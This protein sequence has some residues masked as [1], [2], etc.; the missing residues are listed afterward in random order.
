MKTIIK[1]ISVFFISLLLSYV[2]FSTIPVIADSGW[3][4]DYG[5]W[6]GSDWGGSD[7][8]GSDWGSSDWGSSDWGSSDWSSSDYGSSD[9]AE[10][11]AA[12][13]V[14]FIIIIT[15][16]VAYILISEE[17]KKEN[18][19]S[20]IVSRLF[21]KTEF[22]DFKT[23]KLEKELFNTYKKIELAWAQNDLEPVRKL[24]TDELFN[25]YQML[26]DTML[27]LKQR[28]IMEDIDLIRM[29]VID[30]SRANNI[31]TVQVVMEVTC[32]DYVVKDVDGKEEHLKGYKNR[33]MIY[34]YEMTFVRN[35]KK[36]TKKCP[37]CG[38]KLNDAMSTKCEYCGGIVI[39]ETDH[40]VLSKKEMIRQDKE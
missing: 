35:I 15:I 16:I 39:H 36:I 5:D 4:A 24:L 29:N 23:P 32:I 28:N 3:D 12:F 6:G 37:N 2:V 13:I 22:I 40:F 21:N 10:A 14:I 7:W 27:K 34:D 31:E 25:N 9:S 17:S 11:T 18:S 38:N 8:G 33:K 26:V 30:V 1:Y 19:P 20:T